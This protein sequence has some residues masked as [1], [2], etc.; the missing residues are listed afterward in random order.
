MGIKEIWTILS[1]VGLERVQ[2]QETRHHMMTINQTLVVIILATL[3]YNSGYMLYD[4]ELLAGPVLINC[5]AALLYATCFLWTSRGHYRSASLHFALVGQ[6]HLVALTS[7]LSSSSGV[8]LWMITIGTTA[9]LFVPRK[10][11]LLS[12]LLP[13]S[14]GVLFIWSHIYFSDSEVLRTVPESVMNALYG[15]NVA[16]SIFVGVLVAYF[17]QTTLLKTQQDLMTANSEKQQANETKDKFFSIISHDLRGPAGSIAVLFNEVL[18]RGSDISDE[19][20]ES[21]Q[22]STKNTH[23]LLENL[24]TWA[25]SQK[26]EIEFEP[27]SF[28]VASSVEGN[29]GLFSGP[30]LQKEIRLVGETE[31]GLCAYADLK[32]VTTIIRNLINNAIKFTPPKGQIKVSAK[33]QND[34]VLIEVQDSGVGM[35]QNNLDSLF[36]LDQKNQ[37]SLGTN[38]EEGSGLGLIL[39]SE[40]VSRNG[41]EIGVESKLG[42]GSNFWFTLPQGKADIQREDSRD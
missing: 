18:E 1:R 20:F 32:M 19:L 7:Q 28:L 42:E 5:I 36:Q 11:R 14:S 3:G 22:G 15:V 33:V 37:S 10:D 26:G 29:L 41:G 17:F 25:R 2:N 31:P 39:C 16:G 24:L 12:F 8:N 13:L 30:A 4:S 6:C 35:S 9:F 21:L 27:V 38:S 40:F 23:Q 34:Q